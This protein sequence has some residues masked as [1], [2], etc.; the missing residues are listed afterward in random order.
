MLGRAFDIVEELIVVYEPIFQERNVEH[1]SLSRKD[2][3]KALS[4]VH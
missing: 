2:F 1:S 4:L 3:L